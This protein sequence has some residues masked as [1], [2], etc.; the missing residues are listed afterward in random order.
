VKFYHEKKLVS[1]QE[2]LLL[3]LF[4]SVDF[5]PISL[6]FCTLVEKVYSTQT[7]CICRQSF[8]VPLTEVVTLSSSSRSI[9][10][11]ACRVCRY[12]VSL[13]S[14]LSVVF[15]PS[16]S[17]LKVE[18]TFEEQLLLKMLLLCH[19]YSSFVVFLI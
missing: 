3:A 1:G 2:A 16:K 4:P 7:K 13:S 12:R 11:C 9:A 18:S 6:R 5:V 15:S 8:F 14:A 17:S 10:C 19:T